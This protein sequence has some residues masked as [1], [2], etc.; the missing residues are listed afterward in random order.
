VVNRLLF[1]AAIT[2]IQVFAP[3]FLMYTFNIAREAAASMTGN[4]MM[5]VGVFTLIS[6]LP[7]GWLSDRFGHK[8]LVGVSGVLAAAGAFVLLGSI[9]APRLW[10]IY[11]AGCILGL[12]TGLF[13]TTNWALGAS[14]APPAEAGRYLGISNLAGAGAGMI[15][16]GIGG[17]VADFLN[18]SLPGLGYF[19]IFACYGVLFAL[20][21]VSLKGVVR[22][23]LAAE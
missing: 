21:A 17:P 12:A 8:L 18:G 22:L 16:A 11:V 5:V 20:S 14:L 19:V 4:L 1:F 15:G 7:G 23:H 2:S 13:T 3:Y 9:W 6:A 10:L